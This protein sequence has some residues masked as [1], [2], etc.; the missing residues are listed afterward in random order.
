LRLREIFGDADREHKQV[1]VGTVDFAL[2][3]LQMRE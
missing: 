1:P 2:A 3:S